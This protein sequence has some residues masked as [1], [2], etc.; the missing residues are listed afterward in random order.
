ME[1]QQ[2]GKF[3]QALRKEKE[4]TQK[5]LAQMLG[6]TDRAISKWENGRGMPDVSLMKPLCD[7][8]GITINDLLIGERIDQKDYQEKSE[9][10][11]LN[12][13]EHKDRTIKKKNILLRILVA[14]GILLL[15]GLYM[16]LYLLPFTRSYFHPNEVLGIFYVQK[17]LPV[18][19]YGEELERWSATEMVEQD[20]TEKIDLDKLIRLLPLMRVTVYKENHGHR[21]QGDAVYEIFGYFRNGPRAGETFRIELGEG[22]WNYL[23]PH[24]AGIG[25]AL[26]S[27]AGEPKSHTIVNADGWMEIMEMLEGWEGEHRENFLWEETRMFSLFYEG[28]LYSG[29]GSLMD[30]PEGVTFLE[31][32]SGIAAI[33]DEELECNFGTQGNPVVTWTED[34][35]TYLAVQVDYDKAYG[36][37]VELS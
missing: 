23:Y 12:A 31:G 15:F 24:Y 33:P 29:A 3:I 36:I 13:I 22:E 30:L 34:G 9:Y 17:T 1:Q 2:I 21:W 26:F 8:L 5:D 7:I 20:I 35:R 19:P 16:M 37:A 10:N 14:V 6:V 4:L 28:K 11:F 25:S 27:H 32:V 18:T